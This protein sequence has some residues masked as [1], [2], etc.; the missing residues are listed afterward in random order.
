MKWDWE[1]ANERGWKTVYSEEVESKSESTN[2]PFLDPKGQ[3]Y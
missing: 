3:L 1:G 2:V